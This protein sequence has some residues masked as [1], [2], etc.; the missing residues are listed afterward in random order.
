MRRYLQT[1]HSQFRTPRVCLSQ[2]LPL[3]LRDSTLFLIKDSSIQVPFDQGKLHVPIHALPW[4]SDR[5]MRVSVN[6]FGIG[7]SNAHVRFTTLF[8]LN[9]I[10]SLTCS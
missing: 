6:N 10:E 5:K 7:G 3:A 2:I 9:R 1:L 8:S 4:P